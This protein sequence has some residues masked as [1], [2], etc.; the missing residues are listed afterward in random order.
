MVEAAQQVFTAGARRGTASSGV[1]DHQHRAED[2]EAG[3]APGIALQRGVHDQ[4]CAPATASTGR[5]GA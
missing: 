1:Q 3:D 4:H 5:Q 2:A